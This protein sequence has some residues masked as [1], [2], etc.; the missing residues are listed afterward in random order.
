MNR[1]ARRSNS[2]PDPRLPPRRSTSTD[3]MVHDD[4]EPRTYRRSGEHNPESPPDQPGHPGRTSSRVSRV[5]GDMDSSAAQ[6]SGSRRTDSPT[7]K[8]PSRRSASMASRV[9]DD[10]E[11]RSY[12]RSVDYSSGSPPNSPSRPRRTPSRT[13]RV[14]GYMESN[15]AEWS[16]AR[17]S[18]TPTD[19]KRPP[20]RNTSSASRDDL[21]SRTHGWSGDQ[22]KRSTPDCP[23]PPQRKSSKT[24]RVRGYVESS[25]A[26]SRSAR[27]TDSPTDHRSPPRWS[28][29]RTSTVIDEYEPR[30]Y[31]GS[32]VHMPGCPYAHTS[33]PQ[34]TKTT[35]KLADKEATGDAVA[36]TKA[37]EDAAACEPQRPH[38]VASLEESEEEQIPKP[39]ESPLSEEYV[40]PSQGGQAAAVV[41]ESL[42]P[43]SDDEDDEPQYEVEE[44]DD[45]SFG[46]FRMWVLCS[47]AAIVLLIPF[48]L[49][50]MSYGAT[51]QIHSDYEGNGL[52]PLLKQFNKHGD[53]VLITVPPNANIV[54]NYYP[55]FSDPLPQIEYVI[56]ATHRLQHEGLVSCTGGQ[57]ETALAYWAIYKL[58]EP[59]FNNRVIYST[60]LGGHVYFSSWLQLWKPGVQLSRFYNRA[61]GIPKLSYPDVCGKAPTR[62]TDECALYVL[63]SNSSGFKI[64]EL[65]NESIRIHEL[66]AAL[67]RTKRRSTPGA[68]GIT[69]QMLRNLEEAGRQRLLE[70]FNDIWNTGDI[71]ESWRAAVVAP[72]LKPRKPAT[73]LSSYRPVSLTSAACKVLER[74]AL[75]RLEWIAAQLQFFPEQQSGFR[76]YRCTADSIA[77]VVATLEDAKAC[78]DVA[79]LVLLDVESAF[80]GLPHTVVEAAMDGLG[81]IGCLRGFVT[82]FLSG[83]TFRV[84]VGRELSEPRDI[85]AGVPQGSVL[86]P[87]LF[88]M[89]LAGLP[90]SLPAAARFPARCSIY[91]DDVALWVRGPRR[92]I[93]A[94]RRSLQ[95]ALDAVVSYLGGIGLRHAQPD[96]RF[97]R[98]FLDRIFGHSCKVCDRLWFD[99]NL[100]WIGNIQNDTH[101]TKALSVLCNEFDASYDGKS[102]TDY[103]DYV[104]CAPC[105]DSLIAGRVPA[106][107]VSYGYRY[108]PQPDH[109]P[110]LNTVEER[111]IAP[112]LPFMSIR[113]LTHGNGQYGIIGQVVNVPIEVPMLVQ[114]LPRNVPVVTP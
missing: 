8:S 14:R 75:A 64:Q 21:E 20:R 13:S 18:D 58:L 32:Q 41:V 67:S 17:K 26:L 79:M 68:D 27:R 34:K 2:P 94:I 76:C 25:N 95:E 97:K 40:P 11:S 47:V 43:F 36:R 111:L 65:C 83:R 10:F 57:T 96:A 70:F 19:G 104:V 66:E 24:S 106:M 60:A 1:S 69:F 31:P 92:S 90:A 84:R 46:W 74:V 3:S 39:P 7:Y 5:R 102:K 85:T 15:A 45:S 42:G 72:I 29:S 101:R 77:D 50:L 59:A 91:A 110:K 107:S 52:L 113:R 71:P 56:V 100:T 23:S 89:A 38:G 81:I 98:D 51:S 49:T 61:Q 78:G 22:S 105:K 12:R 6:R 55:L 99:N 93:P 37:A 73:A 109:L 108:P 87:F 103:N 44:E 54:K 4:S 86:S 35:P 16:G 62:E 28:A 33:H 112:R 9:H 63:G 114:C 53:R 88:N 48:S 80:D 82:A 30:T